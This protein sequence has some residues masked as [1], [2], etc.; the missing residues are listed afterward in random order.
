MSASLNLTPGSQQKLS[1][2]SQ[3]NPLQEML[4]IKTKITALQHQ[5]DHL[6]QQ[7]QQDIAQLITA[8][9]LASLEDQILVG[10]LLFIKDKIAI[11]DPMVEDWQ[12]AGMRFL[13]RPQSKEHSPSQPAQASPSKTQSS[14]KSSN[15]REQ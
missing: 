1:R 7:R 12:Q 2:T 13:R 11:Q 8:L 3:K 10:A 9:D 15:T 6:L 14:Q 4:Q 5:Y